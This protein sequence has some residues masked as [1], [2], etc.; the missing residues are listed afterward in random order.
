MQATPH[1]Y[2]VIMAGGVGTRFW[3]MSRS[4]RPKQFLDILGTGRS[5]IRM[6]F[7]RL[8][9]RIPAEHILVVTQ[10][11]Y[12][13]QV[14]EHLPELPAANVLCEPFMRNT[15]PCI[16][17]ANHWVAAKAG[18]HAAEAA[19]V[20]APA[21]HLILDEAGFLATMD[22]ALDQTRSTQQLV[23]LG[24]KPSRPDTGYGYIQFE[25]PSAGENERIR[26]VRTFTEKPNLKLAEEFIASGDFYWNSGIF[27]WSLANITA[28]FEAHLPDMQALF[29]ERASAFAT[30][31]EAD[32]IASI[33]GDCENISIDYGIME[34]APNVSVVL[35][36]FGW[37]DLGTWA[38]LYEKLT[39]DESANGTANVDLQSTESAGNV[40]VAD[41]PSRK[42]IAIRGLEGFIVV[43]T[44]DALLICP[45]SEEQWVKSL[46]TTL[47]VERGEPFI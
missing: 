22:L 17:Y 26:S 24:I 23:T 8:N 42:L 28:A 35:S 47:K 3:P 13:E 4:A 11:R 38:S 33:Y 36:D 1:T 43:D 18:A 37:S 16:A 19:L 14:G 30:A 21:D 15:A 12:R 29:Q 46:V 44:A 20:V 5:L 32:A 6:T 27:I 10:E 45:K 7:D 25:E 41:G 34:K 9:Q 31:D 40:V 2:A 39:Q